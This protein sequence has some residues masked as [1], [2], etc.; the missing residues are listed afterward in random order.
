MQSRWLA[1][2]LGL[3]AALAVG[4]AQEPAKKRM[5][6]QGTLKVGDP[7]PEFELADADGKNKVKLA[8]LKGK[9]I[10][11]VFGSCT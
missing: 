7:A 5:P 3:A 1:G 11:L 4:L 2:A 9:P 8:D 10:V 6:M